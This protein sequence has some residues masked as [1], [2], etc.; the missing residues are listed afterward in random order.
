M[1]YLLPLSVDLLTPG[2]VLTKRNK[3]ADGKKMPDKH[4]LHARSSEELKDTSQ[5]SKA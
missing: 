3:G 2:G 5:D 1:E 4:M